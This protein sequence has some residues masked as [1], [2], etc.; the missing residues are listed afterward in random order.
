[1]IHVIIMVIIIEFKWEPL[2]C[3]VFFFVFFFLYE[4]LMQLHNGWTISLR[5]VVKS[6]QNTR[7][8]TKET[9]HTKM[10]TC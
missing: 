3:S 9:E 8:D 7:T 6:S 10:I 1:M 2:E 4:I 5:L